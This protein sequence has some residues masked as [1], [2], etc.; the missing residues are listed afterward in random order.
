MG[1]EVHLKWSQFGFR[2]LTLRW[3][4]AQQMALTDKYFMMLLCLSRLFWGRAVREPFCA[5]LCMFKLLFVTSEGARM[6]IQASILSWC[7]S[8]KQTTVVAGKQNGFF[9]TTRCVW[10]MPEDKLSL[11]ENTSRS[12]RQFW[13]FR[14]VFWTLFSL[15]LS[16]YQTIRDSIWTLFL[17][18]LIVSRAELRILVSFTPALISA[19]CPPPP[20]LS[21]FIFPDSPGLYFKARWGHC[22]GK[23]LEVHF[24]Q[25]R[26]QSHWRRWCVPERM[27]ESERGVGGWFWRCGG[28][29]RRWCKQLHPRLKTFNMPVRDL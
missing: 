6:Q 15:F 1:S 17:F 13:C 26:M 8:G 28:G 19:L 20:S 7:K 12:S 3:A 14:G 24:A 11:P 25:R 5:V 2:S 4:K 22:V 23:T 9:P 10:S 21:F 29:G 16:F 27:I 18:W